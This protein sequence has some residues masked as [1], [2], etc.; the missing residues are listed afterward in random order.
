MADVNKQ[1]FVSFEVDGDIL[2]MLSTMEHRLGASRSEILRLAVRAYFSG[3]DRDDTPGV[4]E[5]IFSKRVAAAVDSVIPQ[6][7]AELRRLDLEIQILRNALVGKG[8]VTENDLV[9]FGDL[10]GGE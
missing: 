2:K 1:K 8:V 9:E 5:T 7:R 10:D 4:D 3:I 6:H